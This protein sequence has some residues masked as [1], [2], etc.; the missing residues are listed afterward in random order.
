MHAR[1]HR[2]IFLFTFLIFAFSRQALAETIN[3]FDTKNNIKFDGTVSITE[4]INY[5]FGIKQSH[6]IFRNIKKI[7]VNEE[8]KRFILDVSV[9]S[10]TDELGNPVKYTTYNEGDYL[11]VKIGD[12]NVLL[13]GSK[14]YV[15]NYNVSGGLTYFENNDE[16]YWNATGVEWEIPILRSSAEV[17]FSP[18]V[19]IEAVNGICYT[20][21]SGSTEQNCSLIKLDNGIK[22]STG[23]LAP[24][25][26][27][28]VAVS[29]PKGYSQILEPRPDEKSLISKIISIL[30]SVILGG[31]ALGYFLILPVFLIIK[32]IKRSNYLKSRSRIVSA[33]FSP[34]KT[35][36]GEDFT[37]VETLIMGY[38]TPGLKA[39][40][41]TIISLAQRGY[42]KI[43][44]KSNTEFIFSKTPKNLDETIRPYEKELLDSIFSS[45]QIETS[46]KALAVNTAFGK[47]A[48][49]LS[50][51]AG[52]FLKNNK[53][54]KVN[55]V[56]KSTLFSSLAVV[57][58]IFGNFLLAGVLFILGRKSPE[59]TD[60]GIEKYSE[61]ISLKNFL[62]SQ[63]DQID[64]QAKEMLFFE[65]LLPYATAFGVDDIWMKRFKNLY[66]S[67][68][69]WYQGKDLT[70]LALLNRAVSNSYRVSTYKGSSSSGFRS[71][72]SGGHSGGGGGGGGGG[73]W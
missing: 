63:D 37:P 41:A 8:G 34:P 58:A 36:K 35:E 71:G 22:F 66:G 46:T 24:G 70:S 19:E 10:V 17:F 33:W 51:K 68:P 62:S 23:Y 61:A 21:A 69:E 47:A 43:I 12:P 1:S 39:V 18:D 29:F 13:S 50:A 9:Q 56:E 15:I 52:L 72:F 55:P 26:G 38:V 28:T 31:G 32:W 45:G 6:G 25:E 30:F 11:V 64:F 4:Q 40:P 27:L 7:K 65:K 49:A 14:T 48:E 67:T 60:L 42:I 2:V 5:D 54:Y 3:S 16:F 73:S 53:Y 20:G 44:Q 57:S 59:R